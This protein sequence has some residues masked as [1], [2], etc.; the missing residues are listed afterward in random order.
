MRREKGGFNDK[1]IECDP[2]AGGRTLGVKRFMWGWK[3]KWVKG[4]G[5]QKMS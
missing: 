2:K 4:T 3:D 1:G 5:N